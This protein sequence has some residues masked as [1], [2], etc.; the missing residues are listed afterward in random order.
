ML[1]G[2]LDYDFGPKS[3]NLIVKVQ[4]EGSPPL[5]ST[6][7]LIINV[8][9]V[10]DMAPMFVDPTPKI[11]DLDILEVIGTKSTSMYP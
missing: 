9:D 8:E 1:I 5:T 11:S 4:D 10:N 2:S 7:S 6:V 3:Y